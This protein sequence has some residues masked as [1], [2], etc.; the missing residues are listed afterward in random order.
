MHSVTARIF[1]ILLSAAAL[2]LLL[3]GSPANAQSIDEI[4]NRSL[5]Q[6]HVPGLSVAV[7]KDGKVVT[8]KGYGLANAELMTPATENTFYQLASVTKQ[9][10]A[11][12]ILRLV[13]DGKLGL[14]DK[15]STKLTDLPAAW[16]NVTVRQLLTHTSGIK[17]YTEVEGFDRHVREDLTN[18]DV[19]KLV[20]GAPLDFPSGSKFHYS[21]TGFFLLGMIIEKV[22]GK[23]YGDFLSERIF[24]PLGMTSTRFNDIH[25]VLKNRANGYTFE[26]NTL[27]NA[28]FVSP[29]QPFAAGGLVSTVVDMAKWDAALNGDKLLPKATLESMWTPTKL[30]DGTNS[31]YGFG[32]GIREKKGHR[33]IA[34][35][36]GINGFSTSIVRLPE[37]KLTVIVLANSDGARAEGIAMDIVVT[38]VPDVKEEP[39]AAIDDP[40]PDVTAKLRAFLDR[41]AAGKAELADFTPEGQTFFFPDRINQLKG[42]LGS[43]GTIKSME[44]IEDEIRGDSRRR[45]YRVTGETGSALIGFLIDKD[46]KIGGIGINPS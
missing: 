21:N 29:S 5:S 27:Q 13:Q 15:I 31:D 44:L 10:T 23:T 11:T 18:A 40:L 41:A 46:V 22:S 3:A 14:D 17:N 38:Y 42:F 37:D 34:H 35:S 20:T 36:G 8:A 32:W 6:R 16:A 43:I 28:D 7:V 2:T 12:G 24:Q 45:R 19:L 25:A 4:V 30:S 9:F 26:H 33:I 39:K 1:R